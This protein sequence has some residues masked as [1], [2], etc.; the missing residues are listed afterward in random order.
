[1]HA[2]DSCTVIIQLNFK[3]KFL[4]VLES[5]RAIWSGRFS[6]F[7]QHFDFAPKSKWISPTSKTE[8]GLIWATHRAEKKNKQK[9][10]QIACDWKKRTDYKS[11]AYFV[12]I[13]P[14]SLWS[15][16]HGG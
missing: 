16:R 6:R 14:K 2:I 3:V 4:N 11:V 9:W 8:I 12:T 5:L 10:L 15:K 13:W 1:M 7:K